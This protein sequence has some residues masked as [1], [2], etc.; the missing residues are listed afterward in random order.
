MIVAS[1]DPRTHLTNYIDTI[2]Y[3]Q[4]Q[5]SK[6]PLSCAKKKQRKISFKLTQKSNDRRRKGPV[7]RSPY[8]VILSP[9]QM[10]NERFYY[11]MTAI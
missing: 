7:C 4:N 2:I 9:A 1:I 11:L 5:N 8:N 3:H 10:S 6:K